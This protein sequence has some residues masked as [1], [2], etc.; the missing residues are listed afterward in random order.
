MPPDAPQPIAYRFG[1]FR[2]IV[3]GRILERDGERI[4]LTPKV[5]DT[6]FVLVERA[7]EVVTK[8]EL[9]QAVWP[10]VTVVESGL[11]RNISALRKSI[12]GSDEGSYLE[13]IPRRGYRFVAPVSV[14]YAGEASVAPEP[15][16]PQ[17]LGW[18]EKR[19]ILLLAGL[20][21]VTILLLATLNPWKPKPLPE[22]SVKIGDHL[23]YKQSPEEVTRAVGYYEQAIA[24]NPRSAAA[25]AGLAT[26]LIFQAMLGTQ[27]L[28]SVAP[29][30]EAEA[31]LA[32]Q[33]DAR[34][35]SAHC[36]LGLVLSVKDWALD[37][38]EAA[39]RRA[40]E[41]NP[42]SVL[43]RMSYAQ[44]KLAQ[45]DGKGALAMTEQA[46]RLDPA[47]PVLG[48]QYCRAFYHNRDFR[49]AAAECGK[50]VER[51]PHYALAHYYLGLSLGYQSHFAQAREHLRKSGL[52]QEVLEVDEA[53]L[54]A[55]AGDAGP[56]RQ[57][58]A[59]R[60]RAVEAGRV[61][62]SVKLVL[63]AA[64]GYRD[65]GFEALEAGLRSRAPEI[66]TAE[67]EPRIEPLQADPRWEA[68]LR[69]LRA[70]TRK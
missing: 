13:T 12:E 30:A 32:V 6:L 39:F 68:F 20:V 14:E 8:E 27:N 25:H 46:L 18:H 53:W 33:L 56:A 62:A 16:P 24:A 65:E 44:L 49:S 67:L 41:L 40:L 23:L 42:E 52:R 54:S 47:S 45:G 38:A 50:V 51:E 28:P 29:R 57:L 70:A 36:A 58:M 4:A 59:G 31:K 69:K 37:S 9:M 61:D 43:S 10:D 64:L 55:K 35:A 34:L 5:I 1:P 60:R 19:W 63:A 22:A 7:R 2:L 11:T 17:R 66:L 15:P 26:A 3:A 21:T 48:V